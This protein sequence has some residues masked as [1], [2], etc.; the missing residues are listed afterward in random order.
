M[1]INN[2]KIIDRSI[3]KN[4]NGDILKYVNKNEKF[5][6]GFGE[7]YFSEIKQNKIKGW[8][9]HKKNYCL[10]S[11]PFGKV[12]FYFKKGNKSKKVIIG[13]NN[14]RLI[15]LPPR[16]WFSFA[17]LVKLSVVANIIKIPHD[18]KETLKRPIR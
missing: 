10:F 9:Y 17:S 18:D 5:F 2:I 13:K 14:Y 12:I 15:L 8:N 11:V 4:I 6:K 16:I 7:V 1:T 3:I